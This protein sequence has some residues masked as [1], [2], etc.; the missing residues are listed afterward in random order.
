[1]RGC[2]AP[3]SPRV[4]LN[5][6]SDVSLAGDA[7]PAVALSPDG[8]RIVFVSQDQS[9]VSRLFTR[10][11]DQPK[12]VLLPGTD[13]AAQPFFSPDGQWVGFFAAGKLRKTRIHGGDPISLCDAP[14]GR[15]A[16]WGEDGNII[17]ALNTEV[18]LSQVPSG[19]GNPAPIT[20]LGPGEACHRWPHVLPGAKFVLF[21]F[22]GTV[23]NLDEAGIALVSLS[24]H[25]R[26][27]LLEH[28]GT[29]PHYLPSGHLV[30]VTKGS[31]F[32]APFDEKH[33]RITGPAA[34]LEEVAADV[35]RGFAQVDFSAA[36]ICA[37][38]TRGG[39]GL[40]TPQWL[41]AAGKTEPLG[42]EAARYHYLRLSP[43][44]TRLAYVLTQGPT[45][46][47]FIYDW[48]RAIQTRLTNGR[49]TRSPVW[50]PDGRF[51]VFD[52]VGGMFAA[53]T[54]G[55]GT[56]AQ[57]TR[58]SKHQSP[59]T[60]SH[61]GR[62]LVFMETGATANGETRILP[63]RERGGPHAGRGAPAALQG[64]ERTGV[65][66]LLPGRPIAGLFERGRRGLRSLRP[67]ISEWGQAGPGLKRRRSHA[68]LV[69]ARQ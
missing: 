28:A 68:D 57:L 9:G 7:G 35:P 32:A 46:D 26:K 37:L 44:G 55:S 49:V 50:S 29:Y 24:D 20:E 39:Q 3:P 4:D 5:L 51:I 45:S 48:Q 6:G 61:D 16:S 23:N 59:E 30:Y 38:R 11:M 1:M 25:S 15:G 53:Q 65:S 40:S 18:G 67:G 8:T 10:R 63:V 42:L 22:S 64:L 47:L 52:G 56:P 62:L 12:A 34:R 2:S 66:F 33:L 36:G 60:F 19:G 31:L 41:D 43:D 14:Q 58:S 13:G 54:D 21:T 27:T 17:A 69:A